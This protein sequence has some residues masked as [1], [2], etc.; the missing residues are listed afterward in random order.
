M[1]AA[2]HYALEFL[3]DDDDFQVFEKGPHTRV[4][5]L[6]ALYVLPIRLKNIVT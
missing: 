3:F 6:L 5:L 2:I 4:A 1:E